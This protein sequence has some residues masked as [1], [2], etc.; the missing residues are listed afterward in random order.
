MKVLIVGN[1]GREHAIARS[2]HE[3]AS[4]RKDNGILY[5]TSGNPGME[6]FCI[7]VNI[8]PADINSL[9]KFAVENKIGFTV[10]GPEAPLSLG[11][12]DVFQ[13]NGIKIFG[14][15]KGAA[16]IESSKIFAKN[17]MKENEIP[18]ARYKTFSKKEIEE[19]IGFI[20]ECTYPVVFKA[21]GLAAGK[22]VV[23]LNNEEEARRHLKDF[24]EDKTLSD[25]GDEF[26]IE[27][28]IKGEEVSVF[29]ICDGKDYA[30]LPFSQ[31]HKKIS[32]G[33]MGGNTG[34]MGAVAPVKK[35]MTEAL[36]EK[37]KNKIIEPVLNAMKRMGRTY[38]GCLYCGLMISDD[39]P[40]VIEFNCRFG[41]PET[42]AVL[43]LIKSDF[44]ELLISSAEGSI[45]EYK[46][47]VYNKFTCGVVIA[48]GGYPGKFETG[49]LISGL[50]DELE[51]CI[52]FQS[53][54]KA[55]NENEILTNGGRVLT[56]TGISD[57]SLS[58]A[59]YLAYERIKS[60]SFDNMYFRNDIGFRQIDN[61]RDA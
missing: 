38:K 45:R 37:I 12:A 49:K 30:L 43:P 44:L 15:V 54:T 55:G 21:D 2:I 60:I 50:E 5:C 28:Y 36:T 48:S 6:K 24:S 27:E 17:L 22:G 40:F 46:L 33:E 56:V 35:F 1:G 9:S 29:A 26:I 25:T 32:D 47:E 59:K 3:S 31:D 4:F 13:K 14:P 7:P 34:G 53:G 57:V 61:S 20:N 8:K 19:A 52:V 23:I 58:H 42:Q 11:I 10:V 41:D 16:E 39:E 51:Q 18:T